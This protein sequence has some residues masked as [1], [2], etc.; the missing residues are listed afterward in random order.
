M[1][2]GQLIDITDDRDLVNT[3]ES[4]SGDYLLFNDKLLMPV[5]NLDIIE[6]T[7]L[8]NK[9]RVRVEFAYLILTD[10]SEVSW[11]GERDKKEV[12][13]KITLKSHDS[14]I[15]DWFGYDKKNEGYELKVKYHRLLIYIPTISKFGLDW[16]IPWDTPNFKQNIG[17]QSLDKFTNLNWLPDSVYSE[18]EMGINS[19]QRLDLTAGTEEQMSLIK[20]NW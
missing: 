11:I 6:Q 4:Y 10:V 14:Q 16:W 5:I 2:Q 1:R 18:L 7:I 3:S 9:T 15:T 17:K 20:K 12:I 8:S 13:G 19:R